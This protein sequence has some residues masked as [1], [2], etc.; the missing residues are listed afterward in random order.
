MLTDLKVDSRTIDWTGFTEAAVPVHPRSKKPAGGKDWNKLPPMTP[1]AIR[2]HLKRGGNLGLK[3]SH[4]VM[5]DIDVN[6]PGMEGLRWITQEAVEI[7]H[8]TLGEAPIRGRASIPSVA[9]AYAVSPDVSKSGYISFSF[10]GTPVITF[11]LRAT[12]RANQIVVCGVHPDVDEPYLWDRPTLTPWELKSVTPQGWRSFIQEWTAFVESRGGKIERRSKQVDGNPSEHKPFG[13]PDTAAPSKDAAC[14][15]VDRLRN[16]KLAGSK[17]DDAGFMIVMA[18][19]AAT[20]PWFSE[21]WPALAEIFADYPGSVNDRVERLQ[22]EHGERASTV[23]FWYLARQDILGSDMA[24]DEIADEDVV[25]PLPNKFSRLLLSF[26][27]LR[28]IPRSPEIVRGL[29]PAGQVGVFYGTSSVGKSVM[30]FDLA[31]H[32]AADVAWNG[33]EL[34]GGNVVWSAGE[35]VAGSSGRAEAL[36]RKYGIDLKYNFDFIPAVPNVLNK[37]DMREFIECIVER[38]PTLVVIDT[39]RTSLGGEDENSSS[40]AQ[41]AVNAGNVIVR[42]TGASV[43]FVHHTGHDKTRERGSSAL[44]A[45]VDFMY[46]VYKWKGAICL[47]TK[48]EQTKLRDGTKEVFFTY[49]IKSTTLGVD[50]WGKPYTS[51]TIEYIDIRMTP[52]DKPELAKGPREV[53]DALADLGGAASLADWRKARVTAK[54]DAPEYDAQMKAFMRGVRKLEQSNFVICKNG[55]YRIPV[56]EFDDGE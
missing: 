49:E 27:K 30:L 16:Y 40:G 41:A 52:A 20:Y 8:R 22:A 25:P 19:H 9:L 24:F 10:P 7:A 26:A 18:A 15:L 37:D 32:I 34:N 46:P 21:F 11:D 28:A 50:Q 12:S 23:G 38:E 33:R 54:S 48:D 1:D 3:S 51:P 53:Y 55:V 39:Y 5:L 31:Y 14:A 17:N 6:K 45:G 43:I 35:G 29:I 4:I 2:E 42:R 44:R 56:D 13:H 47:G 36:A